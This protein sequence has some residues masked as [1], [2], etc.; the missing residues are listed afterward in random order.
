MQI[1]TVRVQSRILIPVAPAADSTRTVHLPMRRPLSAFRLLAEAPINNIL[2]TQVM[3]EEHIKMRSMI[4][5][6]RFAAN[7]LAH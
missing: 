4:I 1:S 6:E 7:G 3:I 2:I 5:N